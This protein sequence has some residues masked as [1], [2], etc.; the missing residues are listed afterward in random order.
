MKLPKEL[1]TVTKL[2]KYLTKVVFIALPIVGFF[3]GMRYQEMLDLAKRQEMNADFSIPRAPTPTPLAI[4]TVDPSVTANWKTYKNTKHKFSIK[5]PERWHLLPD[6]TYLGTTFL[7]PTEIKLVQ[8]SEPPVTPIRIFEAESSDMQIIIN[9]LNKAYEY[10]NFKEETILIDGINAKKISGTVSSFS[11]VTNR[12]N[13]ELLIQAKDAVI[14][15]S[16]FETPEVDKEL[17]GQILSTFQF[18]N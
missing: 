3:L 12:F 7:S 1:T 6:S 5:Y 8:N 15:I 9:S 10:K 2:S 17:F 18:S 11:Y 16:Y 14:E 13:I 4:P